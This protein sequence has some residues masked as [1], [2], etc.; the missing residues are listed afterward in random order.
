MKR[1]LMGKNSLNLRM[2]PRGLVPHVNV[3]NTRILECRFFKILPEHLQQ[4]FAACEEMKWYTGK[5]CSARSC[6][7]SLKGIVVKE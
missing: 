7:D 1:H 5:L 2:H 3:K 6:F 4:G